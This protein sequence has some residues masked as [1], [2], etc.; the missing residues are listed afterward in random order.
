MRSHFAN[1]SNT[2]SIKMMHS[3]LSFQVHHHPKVPEKYWL[4]LS[5]KIPI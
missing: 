4:K 5:T 1:Q 2:V 3:T